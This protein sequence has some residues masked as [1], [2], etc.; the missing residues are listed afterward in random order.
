[1]SHQTSVRR[2]MFRWGTFAAGA[3]AVAAVLLW[4]GTLSDAELLLSRSYGVALAEADAAPWTLSLTPAL[5][6]AREQGPVKAIWTGKPGHGSAFRRPLA[7]GDRITIA[8]RDG[9]PDRL[10]VVELEEIDGT[11]I[12][13]PGVRFQMVTSRLEG[14]SRGELVRFL[15]AVDPAASAPP[16]TA[17][18][19]L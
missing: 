16:R 3:G 4:S 5:A 13:V 15:I 10:S 12:G 17:D 1:M 18:K 19:T 11:T 9:K 7:V 6:D 14:A 8:S 2:A